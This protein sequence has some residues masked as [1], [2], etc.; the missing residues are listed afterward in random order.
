MLSDYS[1]I[2]LSVCLFVFLTW[3]EY[4]R[5]KK[6]R[7]IWRLMASA[8]ATAALA[9]LI[10]PVNIIKTSTKNSGEAILLTQGFDK[11]SLYK[12]KNIQAYTA[13][14][15]ILKDNPSLKLKYI[16]GLEFFTAQ[17][18]KPKLHIFGYGLDKSDLQQIKNFATEFHVSSAPTGIS[19]FHWRQSIKLGEKLVLQGKFNNTS[20]KSLKIVL[21]GFGSTLDSA[22]IQPGSNPDFELSTIPKHL[23]RAVYQV[24]ALAGKDTVEREDIPIQV[25]ELKVLN[26]L[27]LASSPDF[28]DKFLKNWLYE[29][30]YR[31]A[32]RTAISKNKF[33]TEYLNSA[34]TAIDRLSTVA[35]QKF[36][37]VIADMP[38]LDALSP[39]ESSI[40]KA[41]LS[42][43]L[44]L[45]IQS[46]SIAKPSYFSRIFAQYSS[47]PTA[48]KKTILDLPDRKASLI[49]PDYQ[50]YI[51]KQPGNQ[52]LISDDKGIVV[53]CKLY[54]AGKILLNTI[55]NTFTWPLSGN[56]ADYAS[57]WSLII[58]KAARKTPASEKIMLAD[59]ASVNEAS[60]IVASDNSAAPVITSGTSHIYP[61]QNPDMPYEWSGVFWPVKTGWIQLSSNPENLSWQYV[62]NNNQWKSLKAARTIALTKSFL[63]TNTHSEPG[64]SKPQIE[65][66]PIPRI[67]FF[68]IFLI[69]CAYLWYESKIL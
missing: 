61:E 30:K 2:A 54:G 19:D 53:N 8:L 23:N 42:R 3:L 5:P 39:T 37:L 24:V 20:Q 4:R 63:G 27:V 11:D 10:V 29:Q 44:G 25:N 56:K 1:I 6:A 35:L 26:I 59:F 28:E 48:T 66:K 46:D 18:V 69:T 52:P 40:L 33:S 68:I 67:Y 12:Y 14:I 51:R 57:F 58:E 16:P 31:V 55:S 60:G 41:E 7:L 45:V 50:A 34:K 17:S 13:D 65:L 49:L 64:L 36:D 43:G 62:Y 32:V 38:Q 47:Q 22:I 21:K 15:A 9:C